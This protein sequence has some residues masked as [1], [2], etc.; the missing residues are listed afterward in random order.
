MKNPNLAI[1]QMKYEGILNKLI[2]ELFLI[3]GVVKEIIF[4]SIFERIEDLI[5]LNNKHLK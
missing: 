5:S 2:N 3:S 4:S 1:I